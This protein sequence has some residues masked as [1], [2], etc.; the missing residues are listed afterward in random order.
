V[1]RWSWSARP[2]SA[3]SRSTGACPSSSAARCS[4]T[5]KGDRR[6]GAARRHVGA[7]PCRRRA[8]AGAPPAGR[9]GASCVGSARGARP[10]DAPLAPPGRRHRTD[11]VWRR[12]SRT[13][14]GHHARARGSAPPRG[15]AEDRRPRPVR[16]R[17]TAHCSP[18]RDFREYSLEK[19]LEDLD[20]VAQTAHE[21]RLSTA[22]PLGGI[23]MG[24][25]GG[26]QRRRSRLPRSR[27]GQPL[28]LR[29]Q[30]VCLRRQHAVPQP[31]VRPAGDHHGARAPRGRGDRPPRLT[32]APTPNPYWVLVAGF[33][34]HTGNSYERRSL[35]VRSRSAR[36]QTVRR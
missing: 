11:L 14:P 9:P 5:S 21:L 26:G 34:A 7:R 31:S 8:R 33:L 16:C 18:H 2:A 30:R 24:Q 10:P 22:Y 25:D 36:R 13:R 17:S 15:W 3:A 12:P 20:A 35:A 1:T 19:A 27:H 4:Q 28:C 32:E 23:P 29:R 6:R